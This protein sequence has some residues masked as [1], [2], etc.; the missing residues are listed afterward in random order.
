MHLPAPI[1]HTFLTCSIIHIAKFHVNSLSR[2]LHLHFQLSILIINLYFCLSGLCL[3]TSSTV[4]FCYPSVF[5]CIATLHATMLHPHHTRG[6]ILTSAASRTHGPQNF[7][8]MVFISLASLGLLVSIYTSRFLVLTGCCG[9][10]SK[11]GASIC[12]LSVG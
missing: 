9:T 11:L 12:M 7:Q 5:M 3:P 6:S 4:F 1:V 10:I 8:L 2:S